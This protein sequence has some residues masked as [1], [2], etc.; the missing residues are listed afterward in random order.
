[1][2]KGYRELSE[3]CFEMLDTLPGLR[4]LFD[5]VHTDPELRWEVRLENT[6]TCYYNSGKVFSMKFNTSSKS[7]SF[8]FDRRY[9]NLDDAHRAMFAGLEAWN[10][11]KALRPPPMAGTAGSAKGGHG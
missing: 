1:M 3:P 5:G 2:M 9:F 4:E 8:D 10:A 6:L 7:L 11:G